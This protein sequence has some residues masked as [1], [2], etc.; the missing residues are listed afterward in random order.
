MRILLVSYYFP[1]FNSVGAMRPGALAGFLAQQGHDVHVL[2]CSNQPF[3]QGLPQHLPAAQVTAVPGWSVNAPIEWLRG[4]RDKVARQGF[5]ATASA[6]T[7]M[8]RLGR[9]YKTLLHWPDGQLG[10][11]QAA[12]AAGRALLRSKPFDLVYASAPPFSGLRVAASLSRESGVP[13]V[14][15]LRDLWTDNHAYAYPAWRRTIERRWERRLLSSARALVTV[16]APLVRQLGRFG[17]PVWEVR[18]GCD[19][20]DFD[21]LARPEGFGEDRARLDL[22]FTGN[23]YDGHYDLDAFCA[24]LSAYLAQGG[25]A[26][27]HVAGRNIAG[28]QHAALRHGVAQHFTFRPTVPRRQALAMQGHSDVLL[29]FL[30]SGGGEEGVY[31]A[32]LF[33][34]AAAGRPI[35]AVGRRNDVGALIEAA[36]IGSVHPDA[37]SVAAAL[38]LL[39]ARKL[40]TGVLSVAPAPGHDFS[41]RSQFLLLE[42]RLAALMAG[43]S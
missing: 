30:W 13:W 11:V 14:A 32:K 33:E 34:Y 27:V 43:R 5:G 18:N 31:S 24:G 1:P 4:G 10:W 12:T 40:A 36:R 8:G 29:A 25:R 35:L 37:A 7:P 38:A 2:T 23:V 21:G 9:L 41:R 26:R 22:V 6:A 19:P 17:L 20:A 15:E 39:Q 42:Q 28:L 16:S 3:P